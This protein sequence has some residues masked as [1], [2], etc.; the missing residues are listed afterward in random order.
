[1]ETPRGV[2]PTRPLATV[3]TLLTFVTL[4]SCSPP[5]RARAE[6][7]RRG[8]ELSTAAFHHFKDRDSL[9]ADDSHFTKEGHDLAAEII[10]R[11]L[12]PWIPIGEG[13]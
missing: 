6:L 3:A 10:L 11:R 1:M 5:D 4:T 12:K 2:L 9:F 13:C 8:V 7:T